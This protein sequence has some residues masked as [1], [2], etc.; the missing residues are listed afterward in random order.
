MKIEKLMIGDFM[1]YNNKIW[2]VQFIN[3]NSFVGLTR[4]EKDI[5]V[6]IIVNQKEIEPILLTHDFLLNNNFEYHHNNDNHCDYYN[7]LIG[8]DVILIV[9]SACLYNLYRTI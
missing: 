7:K 4:K 1:S 9:K 2:N 3:E 6:N 5:D 8:Y